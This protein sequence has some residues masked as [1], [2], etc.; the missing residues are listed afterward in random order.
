MPYYVIIQ[1]VSFNQPLSFYPISPL[2]KPHSIRTNAL[3]PRA[4]PNVLLPD[5]RARM[6]RIDHRPR[7]HK[8]PHMR[9]IV[10]A[11]P[12]L[13]PEEQIAGLRLRTREM[14]AHAGVI[15]C[16]RSA[17]DRAVAGLTDGVLCQA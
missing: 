16:L 2:P 9:H 7:L 14:L 12:S 15:L 11:V 3:T 1:L 17:R 13:S 5:R 6:G 8:D 4:R 10:H